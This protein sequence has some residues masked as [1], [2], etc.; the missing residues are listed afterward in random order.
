MRR[1][2]LAT[3]DIGYAAL[4]FASYGVD[5]ITDQTLVVDGGVTLIE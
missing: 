5:Y 4:Y 1:S 3:R 2:A